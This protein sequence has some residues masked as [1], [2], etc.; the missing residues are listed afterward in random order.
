[1]R[2]NE[3]HTRLARMIDPKLDKKITRKVNHRMDSPT[4]RDKLQSQVFFNANNFQYINPA[5]ANLLKSMNTVSPRR[6]GH[7]IYNHD[8]ATALSIGYQE[9]GIEGMKA[10]AIHQA[11]DMMSD[12]GT[13]TLGYKKNNLLQAAMEYIL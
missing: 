13:R 5:Y 2:S 1:M 6:V 7:R 8:W 11:L 4:R 12:V 9:G 3:L 10:A